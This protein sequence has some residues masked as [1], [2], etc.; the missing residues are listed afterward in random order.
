MEVKINREIR[1]YTESVFFGLSLRQCAFAVLACAAAV[2]LYFL[3]SP[4]LGLETL[5]WVCILGAAPFAAVGFIRYHSMTAEQ[6]IWA[7]VKS[8]LLT[9]RR[10]IYCPPNLYYDA[11]ANP[12]KDRRGQATNS[13]EVVIAH[14]KDA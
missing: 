3:L 12:V 13:K 1:D 2:G 8:E 10:L 6:F 14:V 5:S 11:I 9:S 7:W 4:Y